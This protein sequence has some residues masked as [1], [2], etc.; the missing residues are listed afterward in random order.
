MSVILNSRL[1]ALAILLPAGACAAPYAAAV[2]VTGD[3]VTFILNEMADAVKVVFDGGPTTL[4]IGTTPE[5]AGA[6]SFSKAGFST[7]Q[8]EVEKNAAPGWK[9]GVLQPISVDSNDLVK[10]A[11]GRGVAINKFPETG[12]NFGRI[13]AAVGTPGDAAPS[14]TPP[15]TPRT[16]MGEGIYGLNPDFSTTSLGT[17]P[18]TGG[19]VFEPNTSTATADLLA[20]NGTDSPYRLV[21]GPGGDLFISDFSK[22]KGTVWKTNADVADG[23]NIFDGPT[24]SVYPIGG[25]TGTNG[26]HGSIAAA[27]VTGSEA[28]NDLQVWVVDQD[29]Q[30]NKTTATQ[31]MRNSIWK[32][33]MAADPLPMVNAPVLFTS[34]APGVGPN[35]AGIGFAAQTTDLTR[36]VD[37]TFYKLQRRAAGIESAVFAI[38]ALGVPVPSHPTIT[39]SGSRDAFRAASGE[40]TALDPFLEAVACDISSDNWLAILRRADNAISLVRADLG[41]LDF[42]SH[43]L[44]YPTPTTVAGR[45]IAFDAAGNLYVLSSGQALLRVYAPGGH[46]RATTTSSGTFEITTLTPPV[47]AAF[48]ERLPIITAV[49]RTGNDLVMPFTSRLGLASTHVLQRTTNLELGP[50]DTSGTPAFPAAAFTLTGT[51]PNYTFR[52]IGPLATQPAYFFR[53]KRN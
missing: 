4:V 16:G 17:A 28:G 24:G 41:V 13:Y 50:W 18:L 22:T 51:P 45:D 20:I 36:S 34:T 42:S 48:L 26:L 27:V 32:W 19:I 10:F 53:V 15:V 43:I 44:L 23:K 8:I 29:L 2:K 11:N 6:K 5:P 49:T 1:L 39:A 30:T 31:T 7:F 46:T 37:G 38:N 12:A 9:S 35:D 40:T 25:V 33:D 21:V 52:A 3:Q 14:V 47:P